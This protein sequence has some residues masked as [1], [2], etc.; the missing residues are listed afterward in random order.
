MWRASWF[1]P[2]GSPHAPALLPGP[3]LLDYVPSSGFYR[4]WDSNGEDLSFPCACAASG[5]LEVTQGSPER[6]QV[7]T[8]GRLVLDYENASG[9]FRVVHCPPLELRQGFPNPSCRKLAFG[10][11]MPGREVIYLGGGRVMLWERATMRYE[12]WGYNYRRNP[13]RNTT[14]IDSSG[15][16]DLHASGWLRGVSNA[17][18]LLHLRLR[19]RDEPGGRLVHTMLE[20]LPSGR[21]RLWNS[22]GFAAAAWRRAPDPPSPPPSAPPRSPGAAA[23]IDAR[24]DWTRD[25]WTRGGWV[26]AAPI[27]SQGTWTPAPVHPTVGLMQDSPSPL[28]GPVGRGRRGR[29]RFPPHP[30]HPSSHLLPTIPTSSPPSTSSTSSLLNQSPT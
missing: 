18:R 20:L 4:I 7:V 8:M 14:A 25:A 3:A 24:A 17:S 21:Y 1:S 15:F 19:A 12:L 22:E 23:D 9:R 10:L 28:S 16:F 29:P 6:H 2:G 11:W 13:V 30:P 26:R 27:R 5:P